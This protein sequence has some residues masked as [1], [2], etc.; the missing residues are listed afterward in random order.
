MYSKKITIGSRGS[1]LALWQANF[2]AGELKAL[3]VDSSITVIKTQGDRVQDLSFDKLEGKGFF[4]KEIEEA[5]LDESIDLAIHSMKDLPTS[6]PPGLV[7]A[8]VSERAEVADWLLIAPDK[9]DPDQSFQLAKGA[10]VGTSSN[11]RKSML[12]HY[13]PDLEVKDLRGNVPTRVNKLRGDGY[14]AIVLAGAGLSRLQLDLSDLKVVHLNPKEFV[15]APAQGVLAYQVRAED[16]ALRRFIQQE[17]S[18]EEVSS[19]TNVERKL[20]KLL[21]GGCH[22]P[23]GAYCELDDMGNYHVWAA[24]APTA[25]D[26]VTIIRKSSSTS[27]GLSES[28]FEAL[29][30]LKHD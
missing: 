12:L 15:P 20:L 5:L 28:V 21:D 6:S 23:F 16:I 8:G 22:L 17:L 30:N 27:F 29:Q 14:D 10:V 25:T 4:T 19:A 7:I 13:R 9:V 1:K 26:S 24:W 3:G 11:R 18:A 2:V